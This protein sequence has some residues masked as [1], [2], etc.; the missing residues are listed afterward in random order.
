MNDTYVTLQGW[1][2]GD[3]TTREVNGATMSTFR[4]GCTPRYRKGDQWV[5][6]VT[7]WYTVNCWRTLGR[8][9]A[10]SIRKGDPVVVRGRVRVDVWQRDGDAAPS[11]SW[12]VDASFVGHDLNR[13]T[14]AFTKVSRAAAFDPFEDTAVKEVVHGFDASGPRLDSDGREVTPIHGSAEPAA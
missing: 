12:I 13:G 5:D 1:V 9:V 3:V 2:G 6:G 7:S 11:V 10:D 14:T 8:N 4:V